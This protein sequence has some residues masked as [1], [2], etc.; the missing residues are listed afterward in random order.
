VTIDEA[1]N[2]QPRKTFPPV[3]LAALFVV[4]VWGSHMALRQFYEPGHP[5]RLVASRLTVVGFALVVATQAMVFR[6]LDEFQRHLHLL[7]LSIGFGCSL[8]AMT[9]IGLLRAE[10]LLAQA[11][12][13]D[14]P[15]LMVLLYALGLGVAW[16]R[17]S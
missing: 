9:A 14:L 10:G 11:D 5:L 4:V 15:G 6:H 8:V 3:A 12:P 16:R 7:A 1:M 17:Y 2:F 13:R